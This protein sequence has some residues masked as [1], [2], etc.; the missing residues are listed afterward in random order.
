MSATYGWVEDRGRTP[1]PGPQVAGGGETFP[2]E[3]LHLVRRLVD[4]WS[5]RLPAWMDQGAFEGEAYLAA[6]RAMGNFRPE[7]GSTVACH[8][9]ACVRYALLE[10]WRRQT[11]QSSRHRGAGNDNPIGPPLSLD[12]LREGGEAAEIDR[13]ADPEPGPQEALL[14]RCEAERIRSAVD[15][16][17]ERQREVVERRYWREE[18]QSEIARSLGLTPGRVSQV[19]H[20]ALQRLR[21]EVERQTEAD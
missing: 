18:T 13:L 5:A 21:Q 4:R 17:S 7:L 10:E 20:R 6:A 15:K 11:A 1:S 16:L 14:A 2:E 19:L 9:R 3:L 8:V 12:V